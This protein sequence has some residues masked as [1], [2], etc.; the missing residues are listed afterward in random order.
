MS[1][2]Q[3]EKPDRKAAPL[4]RLSEEVAREL[5]SIA[6]VL[7][8]DNLPSADDIDKL[9]RLSKLKTFLSAQ[10][11][12]RRKQI[13]IVGLCTTILLFVGLSF[14]RL[15]STAVDLDV[16]A[17]K[18]HLKLDEQGSATLIPGEMGQI[19]ALKQVRVS[20]ADD[21]RPPGVGE[22]GSFEIRELT[23]NDKTKANRSSEDLAVR[24]QLISIPEG[25]PYSIALGVAYAADSRGLTIETSGSRPV[26]AQFG[27][28]INVGDPV[29][30]EIRPVRATGKNLEL[31]LFPANT[32]RQLT[33]FRDVHLSEIDFEDARHSTILGGSVYIKS[34]A[35]TGTPLQ[36]SDRV[37]IRSAGP[38][39]L[40]ELTLT[41]GELKVLL[42]APSANIVQVGEDSPRDVI[43]TLFEWIQHRWPTQLYATLSALVAFWLALRRWLESSE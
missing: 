43:P 10:R 21:V 5:S 25:S 34:G 32:E 42:S 24:L 22:G 27:E 4:R 7:D 20:G 6:S 3:K 36:P 33:V 31:E 41:K 1:D 23:V 38:M 13:E 2:Q 39:L 14:I 9:E 19:L 30:R 26:T 8:K 35:E 17:T 29:R 18:V 40:R 11:D 15:R 37:T 12:R 16:R 28:V